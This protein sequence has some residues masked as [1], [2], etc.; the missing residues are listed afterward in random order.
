[1]A[2]PEGRLMGGI[3]TRLSCTKGSAVVTNVI[4]GEQRENACL[5]RADRKTKLDDRTTNTEVSDPK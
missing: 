2:N 1:M 3:S 5:Q 4:N